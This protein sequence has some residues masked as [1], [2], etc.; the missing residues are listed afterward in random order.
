MKCLI[1]GKECKNNIHIVKA[2]NV[3]IKE[4]YDTYIRKTDEGICPVCGK[5]AVFCNLNQGY[6]KYCSKRCATSDPS[7]Q[8]QRL[9][10]IKNTLVKHYG[11]TNPQLSKDIQEKTKQTCREKYGSDYAIASKAVQQKIKKTCN[12]RYGVDWSLQSKDI[13]NK[14]QESVR[15]HYGVSNP[16]KSKEI[17]KKAVETRTIN[18]Q[19]KPTSD[20]FIPI[21]TVIQQFGQGWLHH[22]NELNIVPVKFGMYTY[23]T[24]N[25]MQK[26]EEYFHH[27][28]EGHK[29]YVEYDI[30]Q[31][32]KSIYSGTIISPTKSIIKP[33]ELDI[34]IPEKQLAIEVNGIYY[35]SSLNNMDKYYH[36][37]KSKVCEEKGIRLIHI[38]E[39]EWWNEQDKIK[40]LLTIALGCVETRIYARQCTI[41]QITNDEAKPFNNLGHLQ[42]HKNA[43]VTYGLFYKGNLVQLMSFSNSKYN[44]NL[45]NENEWEIIRG[46]PGSNNIVVGGVEKL[47]K[48]FI[49]DNHPQKIFSYCDFN[50]FDGRSY[51]AIGMKFEG[52][53]GPD[54]YWVIDGQLIRRNPSK[55]KYYKENADGILWGS[56]S[57]KYIW[58]AP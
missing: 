27:H 44:K 42:N 55:Y 18:K 3:S 52:Y 2:H 46:C 13:R 32:I 24:K 51:E 48:H 30:L 17:M 4:Y 50:K 11:V 37:N 47:F 58:T 34:Y 22:K 41:R 12:E 25:D 5:E 28:F 38:Y 21:G 10:K 23:I 54:K 57:K 19:T 29:S 45:K 35:H 40:S 15:K 31:Y 8:Q 49:K 1:C 33:L 16:A 6:K 26:A 36:F 53:T 20:D 7:T 56:G 43:D 39:P 14:T 9:E